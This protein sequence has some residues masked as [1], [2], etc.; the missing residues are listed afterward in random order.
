V[1]VDLDGLFFKD[2]AYC[3]LERGIVVVGGKNVELWRLMFRVSELTVDSLFDS[4]MEDVGSFRLLVE[5]LRIG[6][7]Q[8]G[9]IGEVGMKGWHCTVIEMS[10]SPYQ[11]CK[12]R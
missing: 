1:L 7:G 9:D 12:K 2:T 4:S 11:I 3:Y 8:Q 5:E 6:W 10:A